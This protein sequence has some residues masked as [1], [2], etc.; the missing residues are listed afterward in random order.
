M[1]LCYNICSGGRGQVVRQR[2]VASLFAGSI[3]VVRPPKKKKLKRATGIEPV[4][5][6]WKAKVLPL[7][8]ARNII[9]KV[10]RE[11]LFVNKLHS[12]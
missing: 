2:I 10:T 12:K 11:S 4:S 6:A 3:P 1:F 5:L 9:N 8:D 7:Y